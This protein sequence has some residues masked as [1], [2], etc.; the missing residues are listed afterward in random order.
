[1]VIS[2]LC[3][4]HLKILP[5]MWPKPSAK[6]FGLKPSATE[7]EAE[8]QKTSA[9]GRPLVVTS[10]GLSNFSLG[11]P[12]SG[13]AFLLYHLSLSLNLNLTQLI[14]NIGHRFILL[15]LRFLKSKSNMNTPN[16]VAIYL[17]NNMGS[18]SQELILNEF[19][20]SMDFPELIN[21]A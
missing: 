14:Q 16:S 12:K 13:A 15:F 2:T 7:A 1:M 5:K 19:S 4:S 6:S 20:E 18:P 9:F 10:V 3:L 11:C 17:S 8:G 21:L